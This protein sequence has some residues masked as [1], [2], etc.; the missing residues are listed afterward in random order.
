M[1]TKRQD[2]VRLCPE[3]HTR[4]AECHVRELAL[5]RGVP[6]DK[7][8]WTQSYR[9]GQF[10]IEPKKHLFHEGGEADYVYT[11][12][13]GWVVMYKTLA[14]GKRQILRFA[15]PGDFLGFQPDMQG[16]MSYSC[17][18]MTE[19]KLCAFPRT[20]INALVG[21]RVDIATSMI[22]MQAEYMSQCQQNLIGVGRKSALERIA[23]LLC[24]LW[25]RMKAL[26]SVYDGFRPD[27]GMEFP[28]AQEDIGDAVGLT[29]VHV[30]RTI[31]ELKQAG[32]INCASKTLHLLDEK[33]LAELGQYDPHM[34][35]YSPLI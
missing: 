10:L 9:H 14:N 22:K 5:F 8:E 27:G 15:L 34:A 1:N 4:C 17:L 30:N 33:A 35:D 2:G 31:K 23:F 13:A 18:S 19:L 16:V 11:L 7:L 29:T 25:F 28:I 24:D 32:L 12:Y 26:R 6:E 3:P 20:R 21:E